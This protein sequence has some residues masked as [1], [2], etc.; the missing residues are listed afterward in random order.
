M[1]PDRE[2][3]GDEMFLDVRVKLRDDG[4]YDASMLKVLRKLRCAD[5]STRAECAANRE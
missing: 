1:P 3:K 5:D 2:A 4:G